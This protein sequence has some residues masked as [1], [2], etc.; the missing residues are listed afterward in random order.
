MTNTK[1]HTLDIG[2]TAPA[3][4]LPTDGSGTVSL[5]D[6]KGRKLVL[7]FY[8]KDST[9]GCTVQACDLRDNLAT[10]NALG[11]AVLGISKDSVKRH[12]NFKVKHELNF[13]LASDEH[14]TTCEDYGVWKEKKMY[15]KTFMGIERSTFLISENG[16]IEAIWRKV[17]VKEHIDNLKNQLT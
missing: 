16:K 1:N 5:S 7:Y 4:T 11:I 3:F 6:F 13:T 14:G 10:F 12:D 8:P 9:P 2:D 17:K 15:G